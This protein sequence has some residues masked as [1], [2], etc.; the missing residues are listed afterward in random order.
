MIMSVT[1]YL[2]NKF[3]RYLSNKFQNDSYNKNK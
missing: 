3:N 2:T 1:L